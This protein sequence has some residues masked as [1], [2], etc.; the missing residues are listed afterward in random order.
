MSANGGGT[1]FPN[2]IV[3]ASAYLIA[4]RQNEDQIV[5]SDPIATKIVQLRTDLVPGGAGFRSDMRLYGLLCRRFADDIT[6][7]IAR[8]RTGQ[9]LVL[10][11]GLDTTCYRRPY[12]SMRLYE[13]DETEAQVWKR[14]RL[15]DAGVRIPDSLSYVPFEDSHVLPSA[16]LRHRGYDFDQPTLVLWLSHT[17]FLSERIVEDTMAW[18]GTH[19]GSI[20]VVFDYVQSPDDMGSDTRAAALSLKHEMAHLGQPWLSFFTP[21]Q[22]MTFLENAGLDDIEDLSWDDL[23]ARYL[24]DRVGTESDPFGARVVHARRTCR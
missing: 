3:L 6:R 16:E 13:V 10:D 18:L 24:P 2:P 1:A 21:T 8:S 11:A 22:A 19:T 20:E 7:S 9:L 14:Q 5:F 23:L 17:V 15:A 4:M 12:P